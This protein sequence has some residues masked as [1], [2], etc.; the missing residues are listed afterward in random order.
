[1][2]AESLEELEEYKSAPHSRAREVREWGTK[3]TSFPKTRVHCERES[4]AAN[5]WNLSSL[6]A[7]DNVADWQVI[8]ALPLENTVGFDSA[9]AKEVNQ[10]RRLME[11][12]EP[13][14]D[15]CFSKETLDRAVEFLRSQ[16]KQFQ[17]VYGKLPP[18]PYIGAGPDASVDLHWERDEWE[19]LVNIPAGPN[20]PASF[21]GDNYGTQKIK[22]SLDPK[23]ANRGILAWLMNC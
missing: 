6:H 8:P 1:M 7:T 15:P 18:A 13:D 9:L 10:A 12:F 23:S 14:G 11:D 2:P 5:K 3:H 17:S 21:Y 22:G 19:L 20:E 4:N 16:S